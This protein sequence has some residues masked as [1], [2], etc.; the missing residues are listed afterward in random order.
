ML[1]QGLSEDVF[2]E[3]A[4]RTAQ[5]IKAPANKPD[6]LSL[7]PRTHTVEEEKRIP[8]IVHAGHGT[9]VHANT[10]K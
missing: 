8:Q 5:S 10:S 1:G 6:D 2:R 3:Q 7:T 4:S 9:C